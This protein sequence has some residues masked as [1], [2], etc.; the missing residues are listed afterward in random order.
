MACLFAMSQ[1]Q[2]YSDLPHPSR[3]GGLDEVFAILRFI[4][5]P[6]KYSQLQALFKHH[7]SYILRL[8]HES[9]QIW[10]DHLA[11]MT[12]R[13]REPWFSLDSN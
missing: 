10:L 7:F 12:V 2:I 11:I 3:I 5:F 8:F 1:K 9:G 6:S 4:I 13:V